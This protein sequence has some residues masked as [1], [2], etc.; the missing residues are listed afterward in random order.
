MDDRKLR[1][2]LN[3]IHTGSFSKTAEEMN[4]SQS[5]VS[6]M[7]NS[8]EA[9]LG[10]KLLE[11]T[12]SG[13]RLTEA[14]EELLPFIV[15]AEA[16][17]TQLKNHAEQIAEGDET[18]IRIG[19]FSS[20]SK[21]WLPRVLY[22]YQKLYPETSFEIM[23][24]GNN[25]I[26]WLQDGTV[27][28]VIADVQIDDT[29]KWYPLIEEAYCA[30]VPRNFVADGKDTIDQEEFAKYPLILAPS[31]PFHQPLDKFNKTAVKV[32]AGD[33]ATL[34]ALVEM[35]LGVTVMPEISLQNVPEN[36]RIL[37]LTP[38][39]TRT[40]GVTAADS[41]SKSVERFCKYLYKHHSQET[42]KVS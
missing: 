41:G 1:T 6:Q 11:R 29:L 15:N 13:I 26:S 2:F 18:P 9:E 42:K 21:E 12:H 28:V 24:G 34:L 23:V 33:D 17:L 20:I 19:C 8:L 5:A 3:A 38:K 27:D 4:F 40:L 10:C 25:L 35:C 16:A 7:M 31:N 39:W 14:G 36:V 37:Q 30:V 32:S 22:E